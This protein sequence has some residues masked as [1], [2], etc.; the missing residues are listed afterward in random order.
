MIAGAIFGLALVVTASVEPGVS[1]GPN[2]SDTQLSSRQ[3]SA[4][5]QPLVRTATD[6]IVRAVAADPR[7]KISTA[8]GD[9]NDL[10][11]ASMSTCLEPVRAM[12][13][14]HDRLFGEGSGEAFFMGPYL[15]VLPAAVTK[16]V[17]G[18]LQ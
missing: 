9:V 14:T 4:V 13:D 3:K 5:M 6:C 12:I 7:W 11:V 16:Q 1:V 17:K 18:G 2:V 8:A 10:I 15:D